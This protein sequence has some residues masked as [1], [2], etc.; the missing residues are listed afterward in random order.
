MPTGSQPHLGNWSTRGIEAC[1]CSVE[2]GSVREAAMA[3][4]FGSDHYGLNIP[5]LIHDREYLAL[6][7]LFSLCGL[8]SLGHV[9]YDITSR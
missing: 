5:F 3:P 4:N 7:S 8:A 1:S 2:R 9:S 6:F